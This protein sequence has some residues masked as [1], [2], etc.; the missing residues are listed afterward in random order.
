M[1]TNFK[2]QTYLVLTNEDEKVMAIINCPAGENNI[3]EKVEQ[4]LREEYDADEVV[5]NAILING[6]ETLNPIGE[7]DY[8]IEFKA[9]II[10]PNYDSDTESFTL[11]KTA[12]Y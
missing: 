12:I 10:C 7:Y 9:E 2:T 5:I 3:S 11:I 1:K 8:N 4:V 6:I